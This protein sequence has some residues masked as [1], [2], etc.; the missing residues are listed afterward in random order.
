MKDIECDINLDQQNFL[1]QLYNQKPSMG[2]AGGK[3]S[4]VLGCIHSEAKGEVIFLVH[5]SVHPIVRRE[6]G[7]DYYFL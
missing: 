5:N 4:A 3:N 2:S 1:D 7:S 6:N